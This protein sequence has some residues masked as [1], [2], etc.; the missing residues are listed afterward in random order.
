MMRGVWGV[1]ETGGIVIVDERLPLA[2]EDSCNKVH[3]IYIVHAHVY[4]YSV[5]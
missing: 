5:S 1:G 2:R 3:C 4:M